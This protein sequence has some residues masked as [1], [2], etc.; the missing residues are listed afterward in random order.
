MNTT[1]TN[2]AEFLCNYDDDDDEDVYGSNDNE[3]DNDEDVYGSNDNEDDGDAVE[4]YL[5]PALHPSSISH[6]MTPHH[7]HNI[8]CILSYAM[9]G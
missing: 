5:I 9:M 8:T 7:M 3:D 4:F 1:K 6:L 2:I